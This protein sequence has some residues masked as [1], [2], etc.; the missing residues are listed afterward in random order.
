MKKTSLLTLFL[1][2]CLWTAPGFARGTESKFAE[3]GDDTYSYTRQATTGFNRDTDKLTAEAKEDA[4]KYC[5]SKGKQLKV[6]SISVDRPWYTLGYCK[7][8]V[9][10]K[11]LDAGDPALA[12]P[13]PV[14]VVRN[15]KP[16]EMQAPVA[17]TR[18]AP[19][20]TDLYNDLMKLD[21]L[22]Q[23]GILTDEEFQAEKK[24]L[25]GRSK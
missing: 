10:F 22:R 13:E 1:V 18:P 8:V 11:A 12:V 24:K 5:A 6:V 15:G 23:K 14:P 2:F 20:T 4:A 19:T 16:S 9:M 3:L 21:E 25:L 17:Y 7:A